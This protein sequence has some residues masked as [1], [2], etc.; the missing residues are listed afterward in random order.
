MR[1][2]CV[3]T[4]LLKDSEACSGRLFTR[5]HN[6]VAVCPRVAPSWNPSPCCRPALGHTWSSKNKQPLLD[7][8][9]ALE[10]VNVLLTRSARGIWKCNGWFWVCPKYYPLAVKGLHFGLKSRM[11]C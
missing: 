5:E 8:E 4:V 7:G 2:E 1:D 10:R 11:S 3:G 6:G 9:W